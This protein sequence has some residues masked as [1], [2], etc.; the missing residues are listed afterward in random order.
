MTWWPPRP[1]AGS[2]LP[3]QT[4]PTLSPSSGHSNLTS[5]LFLQQAH[6]WT[7]FAQISAWPASHHSVLSAKRTREAFLDHLLEQSPLSITPILFHSLRS[8]YS[9]LNSFTWFLLYIFFLIFFCCYTHKLY[10]TQ[11]ETTCLSCSKQCFQYLQEE[12]NTSLLN[13]WMSTGFL[14]HWALAL[15]KTTAFSLHLLP[16]ICK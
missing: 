4:S 6:S 13:E 8:T 16:G 1:I 11:K 2:C 9:Y 15:S 5:S 10:S 14:S 7:F 12:F 3:F